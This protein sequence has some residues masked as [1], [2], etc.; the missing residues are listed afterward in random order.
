M[1][2]SVREWLPVPILLGVALG[3]AALDSDTGLRNWLSLRADLADASERVSGLRSDVASL[4]PKVATLE[5]EE[6]ELERAIRERLGFAKPG[7]TLV[8][9]VPASNPTSRFP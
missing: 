3:Y 1:G 5:H 7:E 2:G 9:L 6:F 4:R 8:R